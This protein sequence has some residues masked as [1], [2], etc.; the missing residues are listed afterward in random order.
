M[1]LSRRPNERVCWQPFGVDDVPL[2]VPLASS[3]PVR[4]GPIDRSCVPEIRTLLGPFA[5]VVPIRRK[6]SLHDTSKAA[7]V[8]TESAKQKRRRHDATSKATVVEKEKP[9]QKKAGSSQK[10]KKKN[11][12]PK[13]KKMKKKDPDEGLELKTPKQCYDWLIKQNRTIM[14]N[15]AIELHE[16]QTRNMDKHAILQLWKDNRAIYVGVDVKADVREN[17]VETVQSCLKQKREAKEQHRVQ[18]TERIDRQNEERN[19]YRLW[20]EKHMQFL[21]TRDVVLKLTVPVVRFGYYSC[22]QEGAGDVVDNVTRDICVRAKWCPALSYDEQ[23]HFPFVEHEP[24]KTYTLDSAQFPDT[25]PTILGFTLVG[26]SSLHGEPTFPHEVLH[27]GQPLERDCRKFMAHE[28]KEQAPCEFAQSALSYG[29]PLADVHLMATGREAKHILSQDRVREDVNQAKNWMTYCLT[30]D[31]PVYVRLPP[32]YQY[33]RHA[34]EPKHR[35]A[36]RQRDWNKTETLLP[37][38]EVKARRTREFDFFAFSKDINVT[39]TWAI[40]W[41]ETEELDTLE[42]FQFTLRLKH[43]Q[44]QLPIAVWNIVI[45]YQFDPAL[46]Q[47]T[48]PPQPISSN[49]KQPLSTLSSSSSS[50]SLSTGEVQKKQYYQRY[51]RFETIPGG[52]DERRQLVRWSMW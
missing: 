26:P 8:S 23:F 49:R 10:D 11:S 50:L 3:A 22:T 4:Q 13:K 24:K 14:L 27:H 31:Q 2:P 33:D 16:T 6:R 19:T 38:D 43:F 29:R 47:L 46:V 12:A 42:Q 1:K 9:D 5:N 51:S 39:V 30:K 15:V 21:K 34:H 52:K 7:V 44:R 18:A 17:F 32:K 28:Y 45:D 36:P 25:M 37:E 48:Q 41:L 35:W 20:F 40:G